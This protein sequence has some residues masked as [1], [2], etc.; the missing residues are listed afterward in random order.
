[1]NIFWKVE[2]GQ[3]N[4]S[5]LEDEA[6][7]DGIESVLCWCESEEQALML[8]RMYDQGLIQPDN[9]PFHG[10]AVAALSIDNVP[11]HLRSNEQ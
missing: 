9:I 2:N 8:A 1:M 4:E 3:A 6:S 7:I 10:G 11:D 5:F